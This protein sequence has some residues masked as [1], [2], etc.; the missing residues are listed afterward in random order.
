MLQSVSEPHVCT[1][2]IC[3]MPCF[4]LISKHGPDHSLPCSMLTSINLGQIANSF[5]G[6]QSAGERGKFDAFVLRNS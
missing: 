1:P 3:T 6:L 2:V 5:A 4:F